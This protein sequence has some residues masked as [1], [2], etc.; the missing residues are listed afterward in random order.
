ML[1]KLD[2]PA[3][4]DLLSR[5]YSRR[6]FARIAALLAGAGAIPLL[7][8]PSLAQ[9]SAI[10]GGIPAGAVKIDANENPLGP[11][12]EALE[13]VRSI[14]ASG[15]RYIYQQT[16]AFCELLAKQEGLSAANVRAYPGSS[17]PLHHAAIAFTSP[18]KSFVIAEPGYEAG[19]RAA[20]FVGARVIRVPL[21]ASCAH[22]VKAMAAASA[23][24]GMIYV[25]N[26]NNPTG[27]ITPRA[28]IEWL[29]DNKPAGAVILLDEAYIHLS[30]EP[31]C[32]DLVAK[33]KDVIILRTF[34]KLYGMAGLRA[35]AAIGRPDLLERLGNFYTGGLPITA[36]AAA[37]AS[38]NVP[39][40]VAD[41][42]KIIGEVRADTVAFVKSKGF[43][44]TPSASNCFMINVKKPGGDVI[45]AMRRENIYIG[46]LWPSWPTWVRITVGTKD[47]MEKFKAA[48]AKVMA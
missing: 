25:C 24:A 7:D 35:G 41:R 15:G 8:E 45:T 3:K 42:R 27:S 40:L 5:G 29:I 31:M 44:V 16:D 4:Q 30:N 36:M 39:N 18:Q 6:D 47:E 21:T 2:R 32:S 22:D 34:S 14:A 13:A 26:P 1:A 38:L 33:G 12:P 37:S 10:P 19:E 48:F 46:R 11:C 43:E 9:L 23:D 28:D 20:R 17:L